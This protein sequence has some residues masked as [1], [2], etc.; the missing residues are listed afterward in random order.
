MLLMVRVVDVMVLLMPMARVLQVLCRLM[1][2][3]RALWVVMMRVGGRVT[4]DG[5]SE[6]AVGDAPSDADAAVLQVMLCGMVSLGM[7]MVRV[8]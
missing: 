4:G 6:G 5:D 8:L 3:V 1:P 7:P 2:R